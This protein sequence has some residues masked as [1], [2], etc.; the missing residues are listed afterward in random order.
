MS[1]TRNIFYRQYSL[2]KCFLSHYPFLFIVVVVVVDLFSL[3]VFLFSYQLFYIFKW[4]PLPCSAGVNIFCK[5][6][7][8]RMNLLLHLPLFMIQ[9]LL[10]FQHHF[11]AKQKCYYETYM[12]KFLTMCYFPFFCTHKYL[13]TE[14]V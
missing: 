3:P 11:E 14:Y 10:L 13:Y 2:Q 7:Y 12:S 9:R 6:R 8:G 4:L 1:S 5:G